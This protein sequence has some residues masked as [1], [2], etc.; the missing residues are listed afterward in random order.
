MDEIK[1][2]KGK[3]DDRRRKRSFFFILTLED[4]ILGGEMWRERRDR[5]ERKMRELKHGSTGDCL[6]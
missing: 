2:Y 6:F 4:F 1:R 3:E 5:M